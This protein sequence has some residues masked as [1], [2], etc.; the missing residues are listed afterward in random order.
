MTHQE[1]K[2]DHVFIMAA[3]TGGHIFP[4]LA[5]ARYLKSQGIR[6]S[7][8]G[9][10]KGMEVKWVSAEAFPFYAVDVSGLRGKRVLS[11]LKAPFKLFRAFLQSGRIFLKEKPDVVLAMG[12]FVCGPG[13]L[14]A[15]FLR[16]PLVIHEQNSIAGL[17]NRLLSKAPSRISPLKILEAFPNSF[18]QKT[19]AVLTGNPVREDLL[20][21]APPEQRLLRREGALKLL[22]LGGSR[23]SQAINQTVPHAMTLM[24]LD[25]KLEIYH[26]TGQI[27]F[28][29]TKQLYNKHQIEANIVDFINDMPS[30]YQWADLVLCRSGALTLAELCCVGIGS[31]LVPFPYAVDDHQTSNAK[32]LSRANA[33]ILLQQQDL[34]AEEL[35]RQLMYFSKNRHYL[36][37]MA[38]NAYSLR[39]EDAT[40]KVVS[41]LQAMVSLSS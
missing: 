27:H 33:A 5:I 30:A 17:T 37:D 24:P 32:Y 3:G 12:G 28:E 10:P 1:R 41:Y 25:Q 20:Q 36:M 26:Q 9:T 34:N 14:A 8:L 23:G 40:Q 13:G 38:K 19:Q 15:R 7:W 2:L 35:A 11:W 31:I 16:I 39:I 6:V 21:I 18:S 29:E 22:I 4:G